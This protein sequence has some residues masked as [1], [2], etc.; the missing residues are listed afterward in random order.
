MMN[1]CRIALA[2]GTLALAAA[3]L[4]S[5][6]SAQPKVKLVV[7]YQPTA[8]AW[9]AVVI[10][11]LGLEK[12]HLPDVEVE[13]FPALYGPPLVNNMV[14]GKIQL[15]YLGDTPA[16]ILSTKKEV[17]T[18]LVAFCQSDRGDAEAVMVARDSPIT[19]FKDLAGK[20]MATGRGSMVHRAIEVMQK[21]HGV[22]FE[23]LNQ[24]PEVAIANLAAGKIDAYATW[25]PYIGLIRQK[26]IGRVLTRAKEY[27]FLYLCGI[28]TN[29]GFAEQNPRVIEGWLKA[30]LEAQTVMASDPERTARLIAKELE[31]KIPYEAIRM[32]FPGSFVYFS[33]IED[34]QVK[35]LEEVAS[36]LRRNK[37]LD[38]DPDI[39]SFVE[40]RYLKAV[41]R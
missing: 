27:K 40:P 19:S 36:F 24:A 21:R 11:Q 17:E 20:R 6:V 37:F 38:V 9:D 1:G 4:A 29:K 18:R 41:T 3:A 28:V 16:V 35:T 2:V 25:P 23:L 30:N 39:K 8:P 14:A 15:A 32:E 13:W 22:E 12:K 26:G 34:E 7:G 33:T 31:G 10:K 5:Q